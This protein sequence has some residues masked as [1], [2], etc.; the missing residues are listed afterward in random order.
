MDQ[1]LQR[2]EMLMEQRRP[3]E[4]AEI[5]SQLL[6]MNPNDANV[7]SMLGQVNLQTDAPKEANRLFEQALSLAPDN[8][9]LYYL[10]GLSHLHMEE[11]TKAES[12]LLEAVRLNPYVAEYFGVLALIKVDRKDYEAGLHF[13]NQGLEID[14][15]NSLS[16][17][18]RSKA[19][20][21]LNRKEESFQTLEGA[22]NKDPNNALT[23]ANLGWSELEKRDHK[24]ALIHFREALRISPSYQYA[25][26]GMLEALKARF[27]LYRLFLRYTFWM[28][29]MTSKYQWGVII[30][31][32]LVFKLV[33]RAS[34]SNPTLSPILTPI[35]VLLTAVAISTW[36]ANP[37]GNL[38]LRLNK[39]GKHLLSKKEILSSNLVG[40]C[41]L[42]IVLGA[43]SLLL[44]SHNAALAFIFFGIGMIL[45]CSVLFELTKQKNIFPIYAGTMAVVGLLA[46]IHTIQTGALLGTF[47]TIFLFG[48]IGFQW[49]A[50]FFM[51]RQGNAK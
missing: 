37:L 7:L 3:K 5:L 6:A 8:D 24:K 16:V 17:N 15:E 51:I 19:L 42:M 48:F 47:A 26:A 40:I 14:A 50:N 18:A 31:F 23:H 27:L 46:I 44:T 38:F 45:P 29:N 34:I 30:G 25:Q 2:A 13:A 10:K 21:K 35:V 12:D 43:I 1:L 28:S 20:L 9:T 36:V 32:Y 11:Y 22:L 41:A 39:Y 49:I 4:A 33:N